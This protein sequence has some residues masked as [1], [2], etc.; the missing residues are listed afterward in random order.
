MVCTIFATKIGIFYFSYPAL[1][2]K[3][4]QISVL[5]TTMDDRITVVIKNLLPQLTS[6]YEVIISHQITDKKYHIHD[7]VFPDN[8]R[9]IYDYSVG[10]SKNRNNALEKAT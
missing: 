6:V 2:M 5:I 10:L 3:D 1:I 7:I 8:V 4:I 9:Y